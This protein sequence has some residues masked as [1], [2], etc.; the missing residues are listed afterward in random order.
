MANST[1]S[2]RPSKP[3]ADFPLTPH[4]SGR[5]C[6]KIRGKLHYFGPWANPEVALNKYLDQR[7]DLHAGRTPRSNR[8]GLTI[9]EMCN[10]FLHAKRAAVDAGEITELTW[11]D[12][13]AACQRIIK[14]FGKDRF[15]EDLRGDDFD[16]L[17]AAIA[18]TGNLTTQANAINRIRI[19]FR[20][21]F[22]AEL[23]DKPVRYGA[24][25]KRPSRKAVRRQRNPRMFEADEINRMLDNA[26]PTMKAMILLGV[27]CAFG[28]SDIGRLPLDAVD[29]RTGWV[30]FPRPK[31]GTERRCPLWPETVDA[32]HEAI[33]S[34][35]K[36]Q[37][38]CE[39]LLFLTRTGGSYFK[40]STTYLS[41]QFRRFVA[42]V[43]RLEANRTSLRRKGA[44]FYTLRHVFE[45]IG[46]ESRDQ[47]AVDAIMG[48]E[49][50]DMASVYRERISDDRL[51]HVVETVHEWLFS[52]PHAAE[53]FRGL[54]AKRDSSTKGR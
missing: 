48:H 27:N 41:E 42:A 28:N 50:G 18:K 52:E 37:S 1:T 15:V 13:H 34:R 14:A 43:D 12:Y 29:L 39:H 6:K 3:Y 26:K 20:Y 38:G 19:A 4:P 46:G 17:R 7:D 9:R 24:S 53:N 31:T 49:R 23:I 35:P 30:D 16:S 25:F 21:A 47:V 5:W 2:R 10:R 36:A 51:R 32:L 45:T 40:N 33:A 22:D 54:L 11:K 8:D 44:G